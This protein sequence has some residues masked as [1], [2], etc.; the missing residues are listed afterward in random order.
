MSKSNKQP[1]QP[2]P[3]LR[4]LG[5]RDEGWTITD[6]GGPYDGESWWVETHDEVKEA[7]DEF[8]AYFQE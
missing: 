6:H 8:L 2:K 4:M 7:R 3:Y 1:K 5:N